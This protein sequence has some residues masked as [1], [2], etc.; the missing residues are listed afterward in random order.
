MMNENDFV[1]NAAVKLCGSLNIEEALHSTLVYIRSI[2]PVDAVFL[3]HLDPEIGAMRT[4]AK[5]DLT[6]VQ[7]VDMATP[8]LDPGQDNRY[9]RSIYHLGEAIVTNAPLTHSFDVTMVQAYGYDAHYTSLLGMML[10]ANESFH[11]GVMFVTDAEEGFSDKHARLISALYEPFAT[12]LQNS[13]LHRE[14]VQLRDKLADDNRYMNRK[15]Q[16]LA[17]DVIVGGDFGL[18]AVMKQVRQ[19]APTD[20]PVLLTSETGTGKDVIA[21]AIHFASPRRDGPFIAVNC[22]AIPEALLDSELF[23]H[24][25]GAFTG[26]TK[27]KRGRFERAV[28]GTILLDEIGEMPMEA[29]V[30]LLRVIQ[31]REIERIG[32]SERIP[33]DIRIITATN[34]NL[35]EMVETGRFRKDLWF[36]LNVFP[37]EV[38]PLRDR[39][40]DI[41]VLVQH[42][43]ER[44]AVALKVGEPPNLVDGALESL[45]SYHWPGNVRELENV[46]ERAMILHRGEPLRFDDLGSPFAENACTEASTE[47]HPGIGSSPTDLDTVIKQHITRV[48]GLA[49]GKVHGPG[50]A[51]EL[52]GVN[53][54]TLR[55]RMGKLGIQF[56][57]QG[58]S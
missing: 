24:E 5:A 45:M 25:K 46:V 3:L 15:L 30:R 40:C 20:S 19:V 33:V 12:A 48:L 11:G 58:R 57:R 42:F 55:H 27:M 7:S 1:R 28:K 35:V 52:L 23:G 39:L 43:M 4:I 21:N 38:P 51:A 22:G 26:A 37:I 16:Q 50:G 53:P 17:G 41:P 49:G 34:R 29:Q 36:R 47:E 56:G 54:N 9:I 10:L 18:R 13:M 14:V 6:S 8:L 2:M 31:N 32:G 44:K